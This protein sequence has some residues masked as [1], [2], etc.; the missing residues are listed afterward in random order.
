MPPPQ[1]L[2]SVPVVTGLHGPALSSSPAQPAMVS[3]AHGNPSSSLQA[4]N[5]SSRPQSGLTLSPAAP[6]FPQ[7]L[8]DKARAGHFLEMKELLA[9]NVSLLNQLEAVPGVTAAHLCG[10]TRPRLREVSSLT[11]WCYCFLGY[12]AMCTKDPSTRDQMAY[13]RLL[14][15][16]AQRHGG[17][18]WLDYDRAF[19]QQAANDL[20]L[21]WNTLSPSLQASTILGQKQLGQ[22][23]FCTLC[24]G[25]DHTRAHCALFCLEP[26]AVT[27]SAATRTMT[28]SSFSQRRYNVC[29][30]WNR[31]ACVFPGQCTFRHVC[32][33]CQSANHKAKD[34]AKTPETSSY[35]VRPNTP[36]SRPATSGD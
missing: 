24:R 28:R 19:R 29:I 2:T 8:V 36:R 9:D 22:S 33:T 23:S 1:S 4:P 3:W 7:K 13:A 30:S 5:S 31:G 10:S 18:G 32:A 26:P 17:M 20:S 14:I 25:V 12:M 21:R 11:S 15:Q 27:T 34:C 16:E 6:P 35:K